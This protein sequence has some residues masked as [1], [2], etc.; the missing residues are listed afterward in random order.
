MD[1]EIQ[2]PQHLKSLYELLGYSRLAS[3]VITH[4]VRN[5]IT[6][7]KQLR[8]LTPSDLLDIKG[9]GEES[10]HFIFENIRYVDSQKKGT[11]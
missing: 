1:D 9:I 10:V 11:S 6:T 7:E 8:T 5:D 2:V 3:T 4:L